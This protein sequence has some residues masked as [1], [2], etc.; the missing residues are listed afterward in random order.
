MPNVVCLSNELC[1][2]GVLGMKWGVRKDNEQTRSR[3]RSGRLNSFG[4]KGHN[5]LYIAGISGS[6]KSTLAL[7]LAKQLNA[8]TIHLDWYYDNRSETQQTPFSN[9]LTR[10]NVN[11]KNVYKNGKLNYK[12]SDKIFPL[13]Q[14]YSKDHKLIVEGVQLLDETMGLDVQ[15]ILAK[16]PVISMQTS[17]RISF[18]RAMERDQSVTKY[19]NFM[20]SKK[21]QELFDNKV[22]LD[23]GKAYTDSLLSDLIGKEAIN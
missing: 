7:N 3:V 2:Y 17:A 6:G 16:E 4:T 19:I 8:E 20:K 5:I 21:V 12:E 11:L 9:F 22:M 18:N 1:H 14:E 23:I 10:K 15:K 13:L